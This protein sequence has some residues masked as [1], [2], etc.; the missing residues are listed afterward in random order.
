MVA[1]VA[2][3]RE[4]RAPLDLFGVGGGGGLHEPGAVHVVLVVGEAAVL[5]VPAGR[6]VLHPYR[7]GPV[8]LQDSGY[9]LYQL[10]L[11]VRE[12]LLDRGP[13]GQLGL[14]RGYPA[15]P[16]AAQALGGV[17][18]GG[19]GLAQHQ[20]HQVD[21]RLGY[22]HVDLG[23]AAAG[24]GHDGAPPRAGAVAG[25]H[26]G[27]GGTDAVLPGLR[28]VG[29]VGG[30]FGVPDGVAVR[31][32]AAVGLARGEVGGGDLGAGAQGA[33]EVGVHEEQVVVGVRD[34]LDDR[35][36]GDARGQDD[37]R[38]LPRGGPGG[39]LLAGGHGEYA[40]GA[41]CQHGEQ[42][43]EA[44]TGQRHRARLGFVPGR[45]KG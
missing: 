25:G 29:A 11:R 23:A 32:V 20:P 7:R 35:A 5:P 19:A 36:V 3:D 34:D 8:L 21:L 38:V 14:Q 16:Q 27:V 37:G 18:A 40:G 42:G 12:A 30:L 41:G 9:R 6:R 31:L 22:E 26:L 33:A 17:L 10:V 44:A 24:G 13:G 28:V 43:R 4:V 15:V 1:E 45:R 2:L 39:G